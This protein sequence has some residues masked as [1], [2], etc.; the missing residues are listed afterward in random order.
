MLPL[1]VILKHVSSLER[2]GKRRG[3][4]N[5][6]SRGGGPCFERCFECFDFDGDANSNSSSMSISISIRVTA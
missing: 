3:L 6:S 4:F 5:Y 2:D 1:T